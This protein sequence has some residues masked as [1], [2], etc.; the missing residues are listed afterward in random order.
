MKQ[1]TMLAGGRLLRLE[2]MDVDSPLH[3][4]ALVL[5]HAVL[6]KPLGLAFTAEEL[7]AEPSSIHVAATIGAELVG[8]LLLVPVD[9]TRLRMRQV[10]VDAKYRGLGVG[11]RLL[12]FAEALASDRRTEEILLHAREEVVRF[13]ERSGY[14]VTG[15]GFIEVTLKHF[16]MRKRL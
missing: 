14:A 12:Q 9:A 15:P 6:R 4:R 10:V 11:A 5:R 8:C 16:P 7:A 13:Y 2:C 3:Q 1:E